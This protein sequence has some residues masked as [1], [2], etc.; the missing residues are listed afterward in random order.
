MITQPPAPK[1]MPTYRPC[2]G[3]CTLAQRRAPASSAA[4]LRANLSPTLCHFPQFLPT[5]PM[6]Q[7]KSSSGKGSTMAR[8]A[9]HRDFERSLLGNLLDV[10]GLDA[11]PQGAVGQ[12]AEEVLLPALLDACPPRPAALSSASHGTSPVGGPMDLASHTRQKWS[13]RD[14]NWNGETEPP[15]LQRASGN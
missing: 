5:F 11:F 2:D 3:V 14:E 9:P 12:A 8:L 6:C 15:T 10:L 1:S 4:A 13:T 7:S